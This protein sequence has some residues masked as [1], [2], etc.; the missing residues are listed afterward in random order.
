MQL[1]ADV[2]GRCFVLPE[3]H[4]AELTGNAALA[5]VA[6]DFDAD[7]QTAAQRLCRLKREFIPNRA[8][9][10]QYAQKRLLRAAREAQG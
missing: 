1:K 8:R 3:I 4:D 6:L 2:S 9:H 7:M 10:E 5:C